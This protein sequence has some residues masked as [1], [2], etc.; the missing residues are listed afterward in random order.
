MTSAPKEPRAQT[1]EHTKNASNTLE[2]R[3]T[4]APGQSRIEFE[5]CG[6]YTASRRPVQ[7]ASVALWPFRRPSIW[8]KQ[9]NSMTAENRRYT[10]KINAA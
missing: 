3:L 6:K 2:K 7:N 5:E 10:K 8:G 4:Q 1:L 9:N